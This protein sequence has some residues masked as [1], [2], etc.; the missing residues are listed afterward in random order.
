MGGIKMKIS[1]W[2]TTVYGKDFTTKEGKNFRKYSVAIAKKNND[3]YTYGYIE[4]NF[5]KDVFI[6]DKTRIIINNG[7]LSFYNNAEGKTIPTVF[8]SEFEKQ[9]M[10]Q[11]EEDSNLP[12]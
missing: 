6:E 11:E 4:C 5:K 12:F 3:K 7:W 8:V 2:K 10:K 9:E 1:E